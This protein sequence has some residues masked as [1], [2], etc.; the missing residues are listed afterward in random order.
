MRYFIFDTGVTLKNENH[1]KYDKEFIQYFWSKRRYNKVREGDV[2]IY[3]KP[4]KASEGNSFY[5]FGVGKVGKIKIVEELNDNHSV[6]CEVLEPIRFQNLIY[7]DDI[8]LLNYSW[9]FK[10]REKERG[11]GQFFNNYGMNEIH[12]SDYEFLHKLGTNLFPSKN[13]NQENMIL[14]NAHNKLMNNGPIEDQFSNV[15]TRG[16]YQKVFADLTKM[17]YNQKCCVS[18]ISTRSL[19]EGAHIVPVSKKREYAMDINNGLCLSVLIHKC[20]D[21][22]L[23]SVDL[24]LIFRVSEKIQDNELKKYLIRFKNKKIQLPARKEYYPKKE[25]LDYHF[26]K[27]FIK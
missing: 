1:S 3:R 7:Q 5:F 2:F 4:K 13:Y 14:V 20:Y 18:G 17:I 24:D 16:S 12:E 10:K 25:F 27:V 26:S 19:L 15:R 22:G 23:V 11:W 6:I 21:L 8:S 9:V